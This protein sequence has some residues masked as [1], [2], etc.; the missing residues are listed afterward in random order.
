MI[1]IPFFNFSKLTFM[2]MEF[3]LQLYT[4]IYLYIGG[5]EWVFT[6]GRVQYVCTLQ[7]NVRLCSASSNLFFFK[8]SRHVSLFLFVFFLFLPIEWRG[9]ERGGKFTQRIKKNTRL[10]N[11]SPTPNTISYPPPYPGHFL[12]KIQSSITSHGCNIAHYCP[13][14]SPDTPD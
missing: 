10:D 1:D 4:C 3:R 11:I 5:V 2:Q 6:N 12:W 8:I 14:Y 13:A 7:W 9:G